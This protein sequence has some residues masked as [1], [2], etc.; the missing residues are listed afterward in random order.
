MGCPHFL[1]E[2]T[3]FP[4]PMGNPM[5]LPWFSYGFHIATDALQVSPLELAWDYPQ[6]WLPSLSPQA[7][8]R[9]VATSGS[10][11]EHIYNMI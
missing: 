10:F 3:M 2:I 4:I 11:E 5:V 7:R 1:D 9:S 6:G 8:I